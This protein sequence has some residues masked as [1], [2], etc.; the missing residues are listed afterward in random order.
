[1]VISLYSNQRIVFPP[2]PAYR[3]EGTPQRVANEEV[4][5]RLDRPGDP[6]CTLWGNPG[7]YLSCFTA[8]PA[9]YDPE[10]MR[11]RRDARDS[12][13]WKKFLWKVPY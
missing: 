11:G 12:L 13:P 7:N 6:K 4:L 1:M 10:R 9:S 8:F 3:S 2:F 5:T